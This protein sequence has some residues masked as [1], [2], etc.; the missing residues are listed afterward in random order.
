M[1]GLLK[2]EIILAAVSF[3]LI[4]VSGVM[5]EIAVRSGMDPASADLLAHAAMLVLFC[6]FGFSC[7]GLMLHVFVV[8]QIGIGNGNAPMIRFLAQHERG[9]TFA[10]WG[11]LG[12]GALIALPFALQ[13]LG[14]RL[15]LRSQGILTADIGMTIEEVKRRSTLRV[16]EPRLMGDGSRI[17]VEEMEFEFR[18]GDSPV[19]FPQS[20]Y[21]WLETAKND[22]RIH[23]LNVGITPR[24]MPLA[25]LEA[26]Q[27]AARAQL[28]ADG[29]IPGHYLAHSGKTVHPWGGKR[30]TGDGRYW[31]KT[32]TLLVFEP[33]RMD[34][35]KRDEPAGS[36]EYIVN[37]V[38]RPKEESDRNLVFERSAW[39][40]TLSTP[41][42]P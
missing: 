11:F 8:A 33:K 7:I 38:L 15:P 25:Q 30:T 6:V 5:R 20:R 12:A 34:E 21:Y 16:K 40:P 42:P 35:E 22:G 28:F 19:H 27:Q 39:T 18:I 32:N 1:K 3:P 31:L 36:G 26:F 17:S 23:L 14:L 41:T 4:F 37:L 29:W 9:V 2:I 13:D 10:A 24:K